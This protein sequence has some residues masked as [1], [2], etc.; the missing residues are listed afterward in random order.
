[1]KV[2]RKDLILEKRLIKYI[3]TEK[4]VLSSAKHPFIVGLHCTFQ[5][6]T[7]LCLVMDY[8]SGGDLGQVLKREGKLSEETARV[9]VAEIV[10]AIEYL[11]KREI[12][13]RDL[14]PDNVVID[15]EGHVALI[16]FGLSKSGIKSNEV[17]QSF[18]GS[19]AYL[20]PEMLMRSGHGRAIDW[21]LVGALLYEM[22][23]GMP[24]YFAQNK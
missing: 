3:T 7:R 22:L 9:Y 4:E 11:H 14:K 12:I 20:A 23:V 13:Y 1:M 8:Y 21:Y 15:G 5:S 6:K 17:T 18:C 24:P 2:L 10:L 19:V 16:D